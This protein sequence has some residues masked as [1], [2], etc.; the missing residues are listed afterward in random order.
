MATTP[1]LAGAATRKITP[2][3]G[4]RPVFLAGF[5]GDRRATAIHSDLYARALALRLGDQVAILVACDLIGLA[6]GD[7]DEI[8]AALAPRDIAPD[9]LVMA[10][11]HTHSGP[12]TLGLWGPDPSTSGVDPLY[13]SL[14]KRAV[15]EAAI[16]ALTFGCPV[17]MRAAMS[18]M[19]ASY[20]KNGRTPR[21]VD[22]EIA[23]IQ[24]VRPNGDTLATLLYLA[25]HPDVLEG[26]STL[27]S[28]DYAGAACQAVERALGGVALHVSGALGGMLS[29]AIEQRNTEGVERM[30]RAYAEAAVAALARCELAEVDR[31]E[32]RRAAFRLPLQN[33]LF[34]QA[35]ETGLL[36]QRPVEEGQLT[37]TCVYID[38]GAAQMIGVPGELLPRLGFE[39]KAAMPGPVRIIAGLADDELGYI[40][41]DDEFVAPEDYANPGAR[42]EESMS[43][44]PRTGSLVMAAARE[45]INRKA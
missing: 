6:R 31:L 45:L 26:D 1:F 10:C 33:P 43:A 22:D 17:R 19:P 12:D 38:L 13:M 34:A 7:V 42:Y 32:F 30:G 9:G 3:L 21:M 8:R 36:R 39:L 37:T 28:A 35:L 27:I 4:E 41:P 29:P 14:V 24:F 44:G 2:P 5:Q 16:E 40:L 25:C 23:A 11:T 15:A 18:R 20:I